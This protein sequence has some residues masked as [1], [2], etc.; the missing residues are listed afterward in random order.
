[1][2]PLF[3]GNNVEYLLA[4]EPSF[5]NTVIHV[6][7]N[8]GR[9]KDFRHIFGAISLVLLRFEPTWLDNHAVFACNQMGQTL[10]MVIVF[11]SKRLIIMGS[12]EDVLAC[13]VV[14]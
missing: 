10:S 13:G 4:I 3:C 2:L 11:T 7:A 1:M 5:I 6:V 9:S 12:P 8:P 14:A